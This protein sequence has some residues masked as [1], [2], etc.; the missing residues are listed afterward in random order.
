MKLP[1]CS[2]KSTCAME[3]N[4]SRVEHKFDPA[5]RVVTGL[6]ADRR[7]MLEDL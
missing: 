3:N 7:V 5:R 2:T 4:S 6:Q 1:W